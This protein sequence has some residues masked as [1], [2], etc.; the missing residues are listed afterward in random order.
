[1]IENKKV[2]IL[3]MARSGYEVAKL[4]SGQNNTIFITDMKDQD[5]EKVRVLKNLNIEFIKTDEPENIL[6]ESFDILIKNPAVFPFHPCV[7]KAK[8]LKIPVVNEMEVAYH[9]I[10]KPVKIIGVTGSNGKTTTVTLI[11]EV[12]KKAGIPVKLGGNI[13]TPLSQ[14]V[15]DLEANDILLLEISDH[16]L[17]DMKD[18]KTD[19]SVLT[20]LCPTHLDYHGS[21]ENY[22]SVKKKIFNHHTKED[23]AIINAANYD[24][25]ALTK[26][27][28]STKYYFNNDEN[29]ITEDGIYIDHKLVIKTSDILIKGHHNYENILATYLVAKILNVDF[30]FVAEVLKEFKGV[31]HRIEYVRTINGVSFYNDSKSTNPTATITALKSFDGNIHL[32]LGGMERS[33]DFHDLTP[34]LSKVKCIYAIG[35]VRNRIM[36]FAS[37]E[38][39][40]AF[41]FK[42]LKEAMKKVEEEVKPGDIVLLSPAS[43]SWDQYLKFEDRGDEFKN[44]VNH[45]ESV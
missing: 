6:D 17:I 4:I 1:M 11:N 22:L 42:T 12:L 43:A 15:S 33:Q 19:I 36:E 44:I 16:Q 2:L 40:P 28:A 41:E 35:E 25:M 27:I 37:E 7:E 10:N 20:N 18:F 13:G 8:E 21:Y 23:I 45:L 38:K 14:I 29:Y 34:Y 32:I 24:S 26:D 31:E 39:V 5:E 3:G 9:Y 30:K